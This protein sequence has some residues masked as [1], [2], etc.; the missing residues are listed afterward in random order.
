MEEAQE[1]GCSQEALRPGPAVLA[2]FQGEVELSLLQMGG[3]EGGKPGA[4]RVKAPGLPGPEATQD[5]ME[6]QDGSKGVQLG[7][8][9]LPSP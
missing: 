6:K 8:V 7:L 4:V 5:V 2:G 1:S 9:T 3:A